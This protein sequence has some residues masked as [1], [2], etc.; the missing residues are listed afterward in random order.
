M[1]WPSEEPYKIVRRTPIVA[2]SLRDTAVGSP[3][4]EGGIRMRHFLPR[5]SAVN[6]RGEVRGYT[7]VGEKSCRKLGHRRPLQSAREGS[8]EHQQGQS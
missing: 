8:R 4:R 7:Q 2:C 3:G 6:C 5:R 1:L